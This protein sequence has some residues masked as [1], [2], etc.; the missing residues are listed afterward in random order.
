MVVESGYLPPGTQAVYARLTSA[1]VSTQSRLGR[2]ATSRLS[3]LHAAQKSRC[4][5]CQ[6]VITLRLPGEPAT[7]MGATID[8]FFPKSEAGI[9]G[10]GN[11]VLACRTCN[12]RKASRLP[13]REEIAAWNRLA[14]DWPYARPID[15]ALVQRKRCVVCACWISPMRLGDSLRSGAETSTC[16]PRCGR[17]GRRRQAAREKLQDLP[18]SAGADEA[19]ADSSMLARLAARFVHAL[20]SAW[21]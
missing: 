7:S 10:W 20:R 14:A 13:S 8:H 3:R 1:P 18:L 2:N 4:F 11:W 5:Y 17:A 6:Q 15:L 19:P 16:R 9:D 12:N 21:R